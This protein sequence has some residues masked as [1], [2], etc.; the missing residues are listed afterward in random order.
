MASS[1]RQ[2]CQEEGDDRNR[3]V[4]GKE[5]SK[6]RQGSLKQADIRA[7]RNITKGRGVHDLGL[8][9]EPLL[10]KVVQEELPPILQRHRHLFACCEETLHPTGT[11]GGRALRLWFT[12][13]LPATIFTRTRITSKEGAPIGI[14]L[15]DARSQNCIVK[16]GPLSCTRIMMCALNGE[17]GCNGNEDWSEEEFNANISPGRDNKGELLNGERFV[18]LENGVGIVPYIEFGDNSSWTRSRRFR[19]GARAVENGANI[20]EGRSEAFIVKDKR[21]ESYKKHDR[22]SLNDEVWRLKKIAKDGPIHKRLSFCKVKTVR[23]LLRLN[24]INPFSLQKI[25]GIRKTLWDAIIE[26][27]RACEI[28]GERYTFQCITTAQQP[29]SL[30]FNSIYE[31]VG[32]SFGGPHYRSL[33]S[34]YSEEKRVVEIAKRKAYETVETSVYGSMKELAGQPSTSTSLGELMHTDEQ[35]GGDQ[36]E[37]NSI[38][39]EFVSGELVAGEDW[40]YLP[41]VSELELPNGLSPSL[42]WGI[43]NPLGYSDQ[44]E[45]PESSYQYL[46]DHSAL[47]SCRG[48]SKTVWNKIRNTLRLVMPFLGKRKGKLPVP[49]N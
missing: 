18:T 45:G 19:L 48:R 5:G 41:N 14:V 47:T 7:I 36:M 4:P 10:R 11:S 2:S 34:L 6:R 23:D 9:L 30:L 17:F 13:S 33:D 44:V 20:R 39:K 32:V 1:A 22:P 8:Y 25:M 26:H 42:L 3:R 27:A 49:C 46:Q 40:N 15:R 35:V 28:D 16:E 37:P 12:N 24:V 29:I 31:L 21:G 43:G 38:G